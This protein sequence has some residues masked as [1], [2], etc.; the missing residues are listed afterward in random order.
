MDAAERAVEAAEKALLADLTPENMTRVQEA[1]AT[2]ATASSQPQRRVTYVAPMRQTVAELWET[3]D[4]E[5]RARFLATVLEKP[6]VISANPGG[7]PKGRQKVDVAG[8]LSVTMG[9]AAPTV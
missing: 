1:R 4:H 6:V 3:Y 2:L 7:R 9:T 5:E 8:R